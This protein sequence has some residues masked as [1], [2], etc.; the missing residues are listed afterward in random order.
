MRSSPQRT[1][2]IAL[3]LLMLSA[4]VIFFITRG[5]SNLGVLA[6]VGLGV[7]V[8]ILK[9]PYRLPVILMCLSVLMADSNHFML[10]ILGLKLRWAILG[11]ILLKE[12]VYWASAKEIRIRFTGVHFFLGLFLVLALSS[13]I[14]SVDSA[15][16][17]QKA[18]SLILLFGA[19]FLYFWRITQ[20]SQT[21]HDLVCF[22]ARLIPLL[23]LIE[24]GYWFLYPQAAYSHGRLRCLSGNPNGLGQLIMLTLPVLYW[25]LLSRQKPR[26][27][28]YML[29]GM[30]LGLVLILLSASRGS[31]IGLSLAIMVITFK[32][33]PRHFFLLLLFALVLNM[34]QEYGV[35]ADQIEGLGGKSGLA[36]RFDATGM[37]GREEAWSVAI[38]VSLENPLLG[39]GFGTTDQTFG[40]RTFRVHQGEHPHNFLLHMFVDLGGLGMGLVFFLHLTLLVYAVTLYLHRSVTGEDFLPLLA[41]GLYLAGLF[42][43]SFENWMFSAGSPVAFPYWF[44]TMLMVRYHTLKR[45]PVPGRPLYAEYSGSRLPR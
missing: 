12:L 3:L 45:A 38:D 2:L 15:I 16:T 39:H 14:Y 23:Y 28:L 31:F 11:I 5:E 18:I 33:T 29:A 10:A 37:G 21:R 22:I 30:G 27:T 20:D 24:A 25:Y 4:P 43:A 32:A 41:T 13:A 6:A 36:E 17:I 1:A 35:S 19:V 26:Y 44:M 9:S 7:F 42:N 8:L 34:V 40:A